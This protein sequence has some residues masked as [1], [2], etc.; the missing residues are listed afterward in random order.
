MGLVAEVVVLLAV[1]GAPMLV[2]V[3]NA[4]VTLVLPTTWYTVPGTD[5]QVMTKLLRVASTLPPVIEKGGTL[6]DAV[7]VT[8]PLAP[9]SV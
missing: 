1:M 3:S 7:I 9:A 6:L 5:C 2:Q 4:E 8:V